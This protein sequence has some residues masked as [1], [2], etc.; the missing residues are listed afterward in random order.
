MGIAKMVGLA[1]LVRKSRRT[2]GA[3][4]GLVHEA[5]LQAHQLQ[6]LFLVLGSIDRTVAWVVALELR[7]FLAAHEPVNRLRKR[8]CPMAAE[9][10]IGLLGGN[11][12]KIW[13]ALRLGSSEIFVQFLE[14]HIGQ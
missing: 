11:Q 8:D 4:M 9:M 5:V 7:S 1:N 13:I 3:G 6:Q 12:K 10:D 2:F 14:A